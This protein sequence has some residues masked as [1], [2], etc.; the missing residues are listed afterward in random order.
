M[1][2]PTSE[3]LRSHPRPQDID[4]EC[5][6]QLGFASR[7]PCPFEERDDAD[8]FSTEA[9]LDKYL[10]D[11]HTTDTEASRKTYPGGDIALLCADGCLHFDYAVVSVRSTETYEG[12]GRE[13]SEMILSLC[14]L[15]RKEKEDDA[16]TP[17]NG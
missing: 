7:S 14:Q 2:M 12:S 17:L 9:G 8:F 13:R 5:L 15:L 16:S 3:T 11:T 6:V 1:Y 10:A 4:T